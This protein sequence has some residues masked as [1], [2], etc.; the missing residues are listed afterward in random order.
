MVCNVGA[1][2][3]YDWLTGA[4]TVYVVYAMFAKYVPNITNSLG[5]SHEYPHT[6]SPEFWY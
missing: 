1:I 4:V 3:I 5:L 6:S 2:I